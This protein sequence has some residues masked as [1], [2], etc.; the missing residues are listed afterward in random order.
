[1]KNLA[2]TSKTLRGD[3]KAKRKKLMKNLAMTSKTLR[4]DQK[5][6]RKH[7]FQHAHNNMTELHISPSMYTTISKSVN[8]FKKTKKGIVTNR[9]AK[10]PG[11]IVIPIPRITRPRTVAVSRCMGIP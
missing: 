3:Q 4:G 10:I 6:K 1:M 2:M 11:V 7:L 8:Q 5:A 9:I